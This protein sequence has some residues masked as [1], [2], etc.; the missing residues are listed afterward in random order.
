M[1]DDLQSDAITLELALNQCRQNNGEELFS[2][3]KGKIAQLSAYLNN[4]TTGKIVKLKIESV[5]AKQAYQAGKNLFFSKYGKLNLSCA[6]CHI[7]HL[8][9]YSNDI[10]SNAIG[11]VSHY[12][13]YDK[14]WQSL[15]TLHRRYIDCQINIGAKPYE[16]Q[17]AEY[18]NLEYFHT[19]ISKGL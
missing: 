13:D 16:A 19:Y 12:P 7:Y 4:Q 6:D 2:W 5:T 14:K 3:K 15:G 17:S 8:N 11:Q 1:F 18:R 9:K 10:L